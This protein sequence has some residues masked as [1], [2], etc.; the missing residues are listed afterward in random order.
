MAGVLLAQFAGKISQL[1]QNINSQEK[2]NPISGNSPLPFS[3]T[4]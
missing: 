2:C 3:E 1:E 4:M